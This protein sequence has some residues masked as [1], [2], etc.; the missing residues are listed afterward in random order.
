MYRRR[1]NSKWWCTK[2]HST[3]EKFNYRALRILIT[4]LNVNKF[5][6]V[7]DNRMNYYNAHVVRVKL[8]YCCVDET[9]VKWLA[10]AS[11]LKWI[12]RFGWLER[13]WVGGI[14]ISLHKNLKCSAPLEDRAKSARA[15]CFFRCSCG[16]RR[17]S[18][19]PR[20]L[21]IFGGEVRA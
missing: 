14:T 10:I 3:V 6:S 7:W 13:W 2:W 1:W 5:L 19:Y 15:E 16:A 11:L 9:S 17:C 18:R 20:L 12:I 8:S 4:I 21:S